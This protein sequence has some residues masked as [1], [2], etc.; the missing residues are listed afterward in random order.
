M[1]IS[2][3]GAASTPADNSSYESTVH[4]VVVTPP[5]SMLANDL[6]IMLA[7]ESIS[8][9]GSNHLLSMRAGDGQTWTAGTFNTAN[10]ANQMFW[11]VF[12]GTWTQNPA[13]NNDGQ[14]NSGG[15]SG[16][17]IVFRSSLSVP[18]WSIDQAESD[19][20]NGSPAS[21]FTITVTGQTPAAASTVTL[22][23]WLA[24]NA[25]TFSSLTAGWTKP[26]AIA[27]W[28]NTATTTGL[29]IAFS[30]AYLIQ[31]TAAATGNV[32]QN[33]SSAISCYGNIITFT[34]GAAAV[35][36]SRS[37]LGVGT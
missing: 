5:A 19:T 7:G 32:S 28:R 21:P 36:P 34:E 10:H 13:V 33:M 26:S 14:T 25:V 30:A 24:G 31:S 29:K 8:S 11:S 1:T 35:V 17:L 16:V 15:L 37:L 12:N 4:P 9:T 3:F 23:W 6:A 2:F 18:N 22:A 27:Q 20:A